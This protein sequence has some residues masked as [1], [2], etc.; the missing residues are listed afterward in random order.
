MVGKLKTAFEDG[1][2]LLVGVVAAMG[3]EKVV[4]FRETV[5]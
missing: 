2:E 3:E 5:A 4:S 1:K